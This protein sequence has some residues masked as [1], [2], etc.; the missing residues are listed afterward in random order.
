MNTIDRIFWLVFIL[1][2]IEGLQ[3][4]RALVYDY[5]CAIGYLP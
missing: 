2:W 4:A 1:V 3:L 5:I